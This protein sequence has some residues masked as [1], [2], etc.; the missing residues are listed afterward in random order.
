VDDEYPDI[1]SLPP[2]CAVAGF[3]V[4]NVGAMER[5][6]Y[7][8]ST[9][10]G[11]TESFGAAEGWRAGKVISRLREQ[12]PQLPDGEQLAARLDVAA[13]ALELRHAV[14]HGILTYDDDRDLFVSHRP[15][16][17]ARLREQ[18]DRANPTWIRHQFQPLDLLDAGNAARAVS[19]FLHDRLVV[20]HEA[21]GLA[22]GK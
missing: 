10:M 21:R 16:Q 19:R 15:P 14:V 17:G 20:W 22:E 11:L 8:A 13:D 6:L 4:M 3:F 9:A 12:A 5:M 2:V 7:T 1:K 18:T